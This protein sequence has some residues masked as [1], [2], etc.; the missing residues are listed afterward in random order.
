M[1]LSF[2]IPTYKEES[3]IEST[4]KRLKADPP[5]CEYEIIVSD[6]ESPDKTAELARAYADKIIIVPRKTIAYGR[7]AGAKAAT[8]DYLIFLDAGVEI[9]NADRFFGDLLRDFEKYPDLVAATVA[10][11]VYPTEATL[12]DRII[13]GLL[14]FTFLIFNNVLHSG[15]ASG[16][17]QMIRADAFRKLN[18]FREDLPAGEDNDMFRRLSHI[19]ETRFYGGLTVLHSGRRAHKI[20]WPK[21]LFQWLKNGL[22]VMFLKKSPFKEWKD[23]R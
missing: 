15:N 2:V 18:G 1:K 14:N 7:N 16:K 10:I 6:S 17:F 21:L 20:G 23:I 12:S 9:V 8:G 22:W 5:P 4:L 13:F 19:G 11:K 3:T